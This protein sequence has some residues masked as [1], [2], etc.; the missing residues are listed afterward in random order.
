MLTHWEKISD[1]SYIRK[2]NGRIYC[3]IE[4]Y[5]ER[6]FVGKIKVDCDY[7][8]IWDLY[9][10]NNLF[11]TVMFIDMEVLKRKGLIEGFG[12]YEE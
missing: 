8:I 5:A 4:I 3:R 9:S 10:F 1:Y 2:F 12:I 7:C 11:D 6:Y